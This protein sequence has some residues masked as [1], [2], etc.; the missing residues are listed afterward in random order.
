MLIFYIYIFGG[1][2]SFRAEIRKRKIICY[3][4]IKN[5]SPPFGKEKGAI[6]RIKMITLNYT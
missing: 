2:C 3:G 5:L 6:E 4:P 1:Y